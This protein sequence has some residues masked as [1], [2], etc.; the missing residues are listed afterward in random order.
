MCAH[1]L[2]NDVPMLEHDNMYDVEGTYMTDR[3][4]W[5]PA[6]DEMAYCARKM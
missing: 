5:R 6:T 2:S 3:R 4:S 1:H